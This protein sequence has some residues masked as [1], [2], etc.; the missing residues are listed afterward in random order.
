MLKCDRCRYWEGSLPLEEIGVDEGSRAEDGGG[1]KLGAVGDRN[2]RRA[3]FPR[4]VAWQTSSRS[5]F[6]LVDCDR[7]HSERVMAFLR[8]VA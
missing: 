3:L 2:A 7:R 4:S 5:R 8:C 6:V 1:E